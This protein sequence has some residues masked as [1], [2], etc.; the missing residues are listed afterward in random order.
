MR[1]ILEHSY[2]VMRDTVLYT[3]GSVGPLG[4]ELGSANCDKIKSKVNSM[5]IDTK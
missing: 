1:L 2:S 4:V 5:I 3:G